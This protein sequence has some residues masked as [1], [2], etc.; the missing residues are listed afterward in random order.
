MSLLRRLLNHISRVPSVTTL[1]FYQIMPLH[2]ISVVTNIPQT[3][4][5]HTTNTSQTYHKHRLYKIPLYW[6]Y[7]SADRIQLAFIHKNVFKAMNIKHEPYRFCA[8]T[9]QFLPSATI[10]VLCISVSHAENKLKTAKYIKGTFRME[11][12][13]LSETLVPIYQT[14][15]RHITEYRNRNELQNCKTPT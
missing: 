2:A 14:A 5:N 15:R 13:G 7:Q 8:I 11:S 1:T 4:H 9:L 12:G 10:S 6:P 3:Y